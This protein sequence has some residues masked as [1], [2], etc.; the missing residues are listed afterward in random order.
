VGTVQKVE[1]N[2]VFD[3]EIKPRQLAKDIVEANFP[4]KHYGDIMTYEAWGM[5]HIMENLVEIALARQDART[6]KLENALKK[7][8]KWW[9]YWPSSRQIEGQP[10]LYESRTIKEI[11]DM[12]KEALEKE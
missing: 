7:L 9:L 3:L 6:T 11:E 2:W 4:E 5:R 10:T 12:A 8:G 1:Q